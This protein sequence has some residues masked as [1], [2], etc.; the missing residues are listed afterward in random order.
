MAQIDLSQLMDYDN[1]KVDDLDLY[2]D[3]INYVNNNNHSVM[4]DKLKRM[5][6]DESMV[7]EKAEVNQMNL[8]EKIQYIDHGNACGLYDSGLSFKTAYDMEMEKLKTWT[9]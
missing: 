6:A 8:P 3:I 9:D 2:R 1:M 4:E 7:T 5:T